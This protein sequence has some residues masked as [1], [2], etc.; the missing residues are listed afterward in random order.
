MVVGCNYYIYQY[1]SGGRELA[2][3]YGKLAYNVTSFSIHSHLLN[4]SFFVS[5]FPTVSVSC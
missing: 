2:K 4:S 1:V 5:L 3:Q